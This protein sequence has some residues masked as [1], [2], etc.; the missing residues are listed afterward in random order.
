MDICI[1]QWFI[2]KL[3]SAERKKNII[4]MFLAV[5]NGQKDL[6]LEMHVNFMAISYYEKSVLCLFNTLYLVAIE[7]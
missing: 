3:L 5:S 2:Q 1:L 4:H 6:H 7:R